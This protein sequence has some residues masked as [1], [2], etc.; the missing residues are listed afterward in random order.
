M[1]FLAS[2][3]LREGEVATEE[4]IKRYCRKHLAN[5]KVP[6][7]IVF[8]DTLPRTADG[9]INKKALL[10]YLLSLQSSFL[11]EAEAGVAQEGSASS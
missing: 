3:S 9:K 1:D 2:V 10:D 8:V 11:V 4:K 7:R 5:Y 6:R